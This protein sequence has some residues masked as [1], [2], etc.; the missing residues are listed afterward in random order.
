MMSAG[1]KKYKRFIQKLMKQIKVIKN[2]FFKVDDKH[3]TSTFTHHFTKNLKA[4]I[5]NEYWG[6]YNM[7]CGGQTSK[8]EVAM[9][10]LNLLRLSDTVKITTVKS[11]YFKGIYFAERPPIERLFNRKLNTQQLNLMQDCPAA[12]KQYMDQYYI[13]FLD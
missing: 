5:E 1:P 12:F 3:G 9:E 4:L 8:L 11:E 6:L 7:L 2:E 10:L 13:M